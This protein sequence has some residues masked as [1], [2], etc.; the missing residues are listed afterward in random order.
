MIKHV[1]SLVFSHVYQEHAF[2][3]YVEFNR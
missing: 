3:W 1:S 2:S